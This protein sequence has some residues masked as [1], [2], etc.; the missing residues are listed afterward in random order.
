[1]KQ[2]DDI[3][4][5]RLRKLDQ[6]YPDVVKTYRWLQ[7]NRDKFVGQVYDPVVL[8]LNLKDPRYASQVEQAL[9]G[10]KSSHLRV[11]CIIFLKNQPS[12]QYFSNSSVKG[13]KITSC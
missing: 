9:G 12:N 5:R 13:K 7:N 4:E 1:M 3:K 2:L 11:S 10:A 6:F 8:L